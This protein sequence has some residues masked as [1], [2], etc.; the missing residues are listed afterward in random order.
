MVITLPR[1][2]WGSAASRKTSVMGARFKCRSSLPVRPISRRIVDKR[3]ACSRIRRASS[4]RS[5]L[6]SS[7]SSS[8]VATILIVANGVPIS[9]AAA[10]TTPPK[11]VS[12]CSR[13]NAICVAANAWD[14]EKVSIVTRR[15]Y[16]ERK[17]KPI[18]N[19]TQFP[20]MNNGGKSATTPF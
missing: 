18:C 16:P 14:M 5:A 7:S 19:A 8:S 17:T 6:S 1:F 11:T 20:Q 4:C 12:L 9:C 2:S 10:A 13:S 15:A 3:T